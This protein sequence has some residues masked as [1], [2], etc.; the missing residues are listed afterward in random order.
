MLQFGAA[1]ADTTGVVRWT[2]SA[3]TT[4]SLAAPGVLQFGPGS[5]HPTARSR[6]SAVHRGSKRKLQGVEETRYVGEYDPA[7]LKQ[8]PTAA[9]DERIR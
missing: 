1:G 8:F 9:L 4:A 6:P 5:A 7:E 2:E 3:D